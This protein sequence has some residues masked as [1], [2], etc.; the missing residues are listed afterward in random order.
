MAEKYPQINDAIKQRIHEGRW[1]IVGGMWIEPDLNMP[2]GESLVR[3]ILIG[4]RT[5]KEL[6]GVDVRI[7]WNPDSFGYNWQ[8]PQIYKES[9]IDYF[10]TQKMVWNDT[11]QLPLKLFWWESPDGSKVLTYFPHGYDNADF[12]PSRLAADILTARERSPGLLEM[13]DLYG[14]GDHGGGATRE[15]LDDGVHW[16]GANTIVPKMQFGLAQTFFSDVERDSI[17]TRPPGPMRPSQPAKGASRRNP[18][19]ASRYRRGTTSFI[20]S[21]TAECRRP[22]PTTNATCA[23]A[24]NGCSTPRN[25]HLWRG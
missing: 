13:M 4:K 23:R 25:T 21:T 5:Y 9:G 8:L 1:E 12:N 22:R 7:G 14:V 6:Y 24:K 17:P 2:D 16:S 19:I 3:Q 18:A 20:S 11:N 15:I 10:V